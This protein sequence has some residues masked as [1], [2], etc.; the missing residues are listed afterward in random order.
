MSHK[1]GVSRRYSVCV[2]DT[3]VVSWSSLSVP[4]K[5]SMKACVVLCCFVVLMAASELKS[6]PLKNKIQS[7]ILTMFSGEMTLEIMTRLNFNMQTDVT[8]FWM[9][10]WL[11]LLSH[12]AT[13]GL[14]SARSDCWSQTVSVSLVS[15]CT[16]CIFLWTVMCSGCLRLPQ[17]SLSDGQVLQKNPEYFIV[18]VLGHNRETMLSL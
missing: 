10:C 7:L 18:S 11:T 9:W 1:H 16:I 12:N 3:C 2:L 13:C 17:D 5:A 14:Y 4:L 8:Q 6:R 15:D